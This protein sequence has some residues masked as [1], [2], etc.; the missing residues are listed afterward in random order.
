MKSQA[1]GLPD[2]KL[3][4]VYPSGCFLDPSLANP[5]GSNFAGNPAKATF[6][7]FK[8]GNFEEISQCG[9]AGDP[10]CC[11]SLHE[12]N[13]SREERNEDIL[14]GGHDATSFFLRIDFVIMFHVPVL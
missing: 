5:W 12:S 2:L 8:D 9:P 14:Y 13:M 10:V 1:K 4:Y 7:K 3:S 11:A 6:S